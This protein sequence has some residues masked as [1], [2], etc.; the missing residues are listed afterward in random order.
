MIPPSVG[1]RSR[2]RSITRAGTSVKRRAPSRFAWSAFIAGL[3]CLAMGCSSH[4]GS[5]ARDA[6]PDSAADGPRAT[7][8]TGHAGDAAAGSVICGGARCT[9]PF[10]AGI[11]RLTACCT[12]RGECG[13]SLPGVSKCLPKDL[14]GTQ[15]P[16]GCPATAFMTPG[17]DALGACCG[18]N[19]C[20]VLDPFLG[21]IPRQYVGE[22]AISCDPTQDCTVVAALPCDG[23]EDCPS[24]QRCCGRLAGLA[25]VEFGCFESC[26]GLPDAGA[27]SFWRELCHAGD[28]CESGSSCLT[29]QYLLASLARCD[30]VGAPPDPGL[31]RAKGRINCGTNV[32]GDGEKCCV[33]SPHPPYCAPKAASC[34]CRPGD[35]GPP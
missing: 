31:D 18:P 15:G 27:M 22:Q 3:H 13:L 23:A 29:S 21:C 10:G 16:A 2:V 30:V 24:G 12:E 19:G 33:R 28:P 14:P 35:G 1:L 26:L 5:E 6:G 25:Y 20:G 32:C 34:E 8:D 11:E 4:R 17:G 7:D 9:L